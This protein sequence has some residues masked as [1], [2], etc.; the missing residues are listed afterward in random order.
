MQIFDGEKG[1][2]YI[3]KSNFVKQSEKVWKALE[4]DGIEERLSFFSILTMMAFLE[5]REQKCDYVV[6]E[7]GL[8]GRLDATNIINKPE[9]VALTSIG[10]DHVEV[11]GN[12]LR[13][14]SSEKAEIIK[15][16]T[17]SVVLGP[18]CH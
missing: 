5:F 18:T 1:V 3:S 16:Q 17:P 10:F 12:T 6:L 7:C 8:G 2:T 4:Q 14:I 11:L 13:E 9:C 15:E